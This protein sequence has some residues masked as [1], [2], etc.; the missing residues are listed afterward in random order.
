MAGHQKGRG[1]RRFFGVLLLVGGVVTGCGSPLAGVCADPVQFVDQI[2]A[3]VALIVGP[4][5][6]D[7]TWA[8][9]DGLREGMVLSLG[10]PSEPCRKL[11]LRRTLALRA[12]VEPNFGTYR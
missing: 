12:M 9:A 2:D 7:V 6:D 4:G 5:P 8:S 10:V 3:G 11:H 1:F